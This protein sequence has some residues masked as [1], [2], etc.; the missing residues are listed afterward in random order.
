MTT[1]M[2]KAR[3]GLEMCQIFILVILKILPRISRGDEMIG[4]K[5]SIVE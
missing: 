1:A 5:G 4:L 3:S 2:L